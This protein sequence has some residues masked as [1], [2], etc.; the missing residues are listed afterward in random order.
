M[1]FLFIQLYIFFIVSCNRVK[2]HT[3]YGHILYI[4]IR[5][6]YDIENLSFT[7]KFISIEI[8]DLGQDNREPYNK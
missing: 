5:K 8:T 4:Q 2:N 1:F 6:T 7:Y 3:F